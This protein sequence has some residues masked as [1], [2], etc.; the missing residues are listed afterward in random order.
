M[1]DPWDMRI[2]KEVR[3]KTLGD[4]LRDR[5]EELGLTVRGI[6]DKSKLSEKLVKAL[7]E[8]NYELFPAKVY[9]RGVLDKLASAISYL[10]SREMEARFEKVWIRAAE[11]KSAPRPVGG[12]AAQAGIFINPR[13]AGFILV[14]SIFLAFGGF[15][16]LR[17]AR[18]LA[19]P[20]L[21]VQEPSE[22]SILSEPVL[23][24]SGKAE[25]ESRLTVNGRELRV[26]TDGNFNDQIELGAGVHRLE[27]LVEDRFGKERKELRYVS[28]Q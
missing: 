15:L 1:K 5:R 10:V 26:D 18:F 7:E 13:L 23:R 27:F 25:K 4:L 11:K 24:V 6:A 14:F 17:T 21:A 8:D 2:E 9:A 28:V 12:N 22:G 16:A 19:L 3:D 20:G